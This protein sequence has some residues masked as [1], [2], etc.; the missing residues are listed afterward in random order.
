MFPGIVTCK[1]TAMINF[2]WI[3]ILIFSIA[4]LCSCGEE[5]V[6]GRSAYTFETVIDGEIRIARIMKPVNECVRAPVLFYFHGR[7]G[8]ALNSAAS[9]KFHNIKLLVENP[10]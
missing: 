3:F 10:V 5:C 2:K 1:F 8:S 6:V 9:L 4:I 7:G